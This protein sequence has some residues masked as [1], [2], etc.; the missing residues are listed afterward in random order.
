MER[1]RAGLEVW[2]IISDGLYGVIKCSRIIVRIVAQFCEYTK[3]HQI[4]H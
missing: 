4:I 3:S 1:L 2:E